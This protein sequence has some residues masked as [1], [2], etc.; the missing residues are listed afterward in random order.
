MIDESLLILWFHCKYVDL[1]NCAAV[2][3]DR[4]HSFFLLLSFG[5]GRAAND[6]FIEKEPAQDQSADALLLV[7][8]PQTLCE[9]TEPP[10]REVA[11]LTF[12]D[13]PFIDCT[14]LR[15][16]VGQRSIVRYVSAPVIGP[17][18]SLKDIIWRAFGFRR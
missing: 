12:T 18:P 13:L 3:F 16:L 7:A 14:H 1:G 6:R 4:R 8:G 5:H 2:C 15:L 10:W 9:R 11:G 17:T